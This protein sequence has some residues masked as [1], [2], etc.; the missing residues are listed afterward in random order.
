MPCATSIQEHRRPVQ[1]SPWPVLAR[2]FTLNEYTIYSDYYIS[3]TG[4]NSY[5]LRERKDARHRVIGMTDDFDRPDSTDCKEYENKHYWCLIVT[6]QQ[7]NRKS[8]NQRVAELG[9]AQ[10]ERLRV[11]L[12]HVTKLQI[13]L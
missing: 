5:Q 13:L 9:A 10:I 1:T 3:T 7:I 8:S 11:T 2:N 12:L 6:I 4:I